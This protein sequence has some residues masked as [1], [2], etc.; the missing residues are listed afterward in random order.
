MPNNGFW[1]V[2]VHSH[3]RFAPMYLLIAFC[4]PQWSLLIEDTLYPCCSLHK[5]DVFYTA[6]ILAALWK[7]E[8]LWRN[9]AR[10]NM[11]HDTLKAMH[12]LALCINNMAAFNYTFRRKVLSL[13]FL[14]VSFGFLMPNN[15]CLGCWMS[16]VEF[17]RKQEKLISRRR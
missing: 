12:F 10:N 2:K 7:R 15:A 13:N 1:Q 3:K 14:V 5:K 8:V 4:C 9:K 16:K 11:S 6:C 17:L